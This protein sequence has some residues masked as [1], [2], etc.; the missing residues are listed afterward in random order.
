MR[1]FVPEL[2]KTEIENWK[3]T[4]MSR[5]LSPESIRMNNDVI[6]YIWQYFQ[7][8]T[9]TLKKQLFA[10]IIVK[11]NGK[12]ALRKKANAKKYVIRKKV[13][14]KKNMHWRH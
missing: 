12:K 7:L 2:Y 3:T 11:S 13:P 5:I 1:E 14:I 10:T 6:D 4:Y 9:G 8:K